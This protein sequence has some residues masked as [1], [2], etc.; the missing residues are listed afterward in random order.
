MIELVLPW[1]PTV[2]TYYRNVAGKTLI[3]EKGRQYRYAVL[4]QVL[5]QGGSHGYK[6]RLGVLIEAHVPDKRNRDLDNLFKSVLDSLTKA[7]VWDDDGQIDELSIKRMPVGG[8][9]RVKVWT[10]NSI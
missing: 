6:G 10:L 5:L 9:L 1:P 2:N 4:E 8:M 7:G 3:S